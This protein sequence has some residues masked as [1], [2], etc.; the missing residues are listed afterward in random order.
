MKKDITNKLGTES[1]GRLLLNLA[2]PAII[3]QLVNMLYNIV[4]RIYIGHIPGIG[5][6]ALTG[7]GVTFPIIMIIT[8]F[9]SLI[10][11]GGAP[12]AAIKMGEQRDDLAEE[13]LGNCFTL[14]IG[15]AIILTILFL[16]TGERLLMMFGASSETISYG[17]SYLNIYVAGTIFVM[18]TL[19]LN[20]F[21][22]TQGF[23]KIS[24]LTVVIGAVINIILDPILIFGFNMGVQGAAI[25]TV[26]SQAVSAIW[27]LRFMVGEKTKLKIHKRYLKLKK[28]AII[29]VLMLGISP[30]I[31]NST[32]SLLNISLNA[33]LQKYGGDIAVGAMTILSSLM[34]IMFLP[35]AGLTQGAQPII[36][37]NYGAKNNERVKETFKLLIL[38][39]MIF[40]LVLWTLMM[41]FPKVF[42]SLFTKDI[43]L[44]NITV[45]AMRIYLGAGVVLGAQI[46]CQQTFIAIGQAKIS[47]FL[48]LLRKIIL[49]I[50]LIYVLPI[51]FKDKVFA[52]FFAEPIAD[53]I[54]VTVTVVVFA[55]QFKKLLLENI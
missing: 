28:E 40:S 32:E 36:S 16:I 19:G 20:S 24:M 34:Q 33:S 49:L 23:S 13:I 43:E 17:L 1:V 39:A 3:A 31:M 8:A 15:I 42:V 55:I 45:W 52:V 46:A 54:A 12:R 48:A 29:P 47:L 51:F 7:V 5:A 44:M 18:I 30:F 41:I 26:I 11:M 21:I 6:T 4:D 53:I 2:L 27:V 50:P 35:L 38:S 10:G 22:S 9:S 37:Y 25:A 14:L